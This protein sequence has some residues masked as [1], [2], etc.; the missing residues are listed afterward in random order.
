MCGLQYD[1]VP[2]GSHSGKLFVLQE[3]LN[4]NLFWWIEAILPRLGFATDR[5][6]KNAKYNRVNEEGR[7]QDSDMHFIYV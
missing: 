1:P 2:L 5:Q 4:Q 7:E 6:E 3:Y